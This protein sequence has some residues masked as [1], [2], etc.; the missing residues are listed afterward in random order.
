MAL[1]LD[2]SRPRR[3]ARPFGEVT[4]IIE[5]TNA[6]DAISQIADF[7]ARHQGFR[8][9]VPDTSF[10]PFSAICR[11][12]LTFPSGTYSGTG[13][14]IG[15]S[16][17]LSCG[18]NLFD[19]TPDGSS[20][21]AATAVTVRVGQQNATTWLDS[22][23][24][25]PSDWTVHPTWVS[26][27]ATN[28]GFDLSV[29]RVSHAPPGGNYF[30]MINYSPSPETPIA[31][32]G[33][34]GEDVDSDRQHLDIDRVRGLSDDFE[35]FD[36]NLQTRKGNSGS[37]V[38]AHFTNTSS[39]LPESIPVMGVHVAG[40]SGALNRGVLL[41]PDKIEWALG[42][43]ISSVSA[44][45]LGRSS[46][47]GLP[48]QRRNPAML[49]GLPLAASGRQ[50][51]LRT[52]SYARP[53]ERSWIVVDLSPTGGMGVPKRT[54]GHP[55]RD[56]SG[57]TTLSV[58]VPNMPAGGSVLWNIPDATHKTIAS[59]E[60]GG[61]PETFVS[62]L[63]AT[64]RS[65]NGGSFAVDCMV[66]DAAGKTVES[67]KYWLSSPQFVLVA[68][69][70][71]TDAFLTS[72]GLGASR[73][74][75]LAEMK[76][77]ME[78]IYRNVNMRFIFPGEALPA[79]L[80]IRANAAFPAGI[81]A[82]PSVIYAEMLGDETIMDPEAT[83]AA[84]APTAY[85]AGV[86]GRNH[87]PG[88]MAGPMAGHTLARGLVH[89][90]APLFPDINALQARTT[91]GT[92][93][94]AEMGRA[95][96]FY[97]R[98]MGENMAHEVAHFAVAA[99]QAH[100]PSGLTE[101]G[102]GRSTLERT[103]MTIN[104]GTGAI[105]DAGRATINDLPPDVLRAFEEHL[106]INPPHD[107]AGVTARGRVG[108]FSRSTG[109]VNRSARQ[110]SGEITVHLP[111]TTILDGWEAE[112]FVVA[113][114]TA[115][116]SVLGTN[117]AF[118]LLAPFVDVDL[119]LSAC[120]RAGATLALGISGTLGLGDGFGVSAGIVFAPGHRIG[121]YGTGAGVIGMIYNAGGSVQITLIDGG[122]EKLAGD[123]YMAGI[124]VATLG[125]F[126]AGTLDAPVGAHMLFDMAHNPI[127]VT[128]E[129]GISAGLPVISLIEAYG[130]RT[131]TVTTLARRR[132]GRSLSVPPGAIDH[133]VDTAIAHGAS[134]ADAQAFL[135][136]LIG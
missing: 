118:M 135:S 50:P 109:W 15:N 1:P 49:G 2:Y 114:E 4:P 59:L 16:L 130:Q 55:T 28:R 128:F 40:H 99:F 121:F 126:D 119:I 20:T 13:F 19:T 57:K 42:G 77:T 92:L 54:F 106:P 90:F 67:N 43:G 127:G 120:D 35:N 98:L 133:A 22:F 110:L 53:L 46:L 124:S 91:A 125:W 51:M 11:L 69:N 8:I 10:F 85:G 48:L 25:T 71:T 80:G 26:S 108:S 122:P 24:V 96:T 61:K 5:A 52:Q 63:N 113:L 47:G 75:I 78:H 32:C 70:P 65:L 7:V 103:G 111:G 102:S 116:R 88:D 12:K 76:A 60:S 38:F 34:G 17:I 82:Q 73:A 87:Q 131:K 33:Y 112:A 66:K 44:F 39:E 62:G 37:P 134:P 94:A 36:Y 45:S 105:T 129:F 23:E 86:L 89:R 79:H 100:T 6:W 117:P 115:M 14:Y 27:G 58:R 95:A 123:G 31:V 97:G 30:H 64:L 9:G 72:I 107:Q 83:L 136:R 101:D 104:L 68:I 132:H 56:A 41:T 84:G 18:H 81:E 3:A 93:P 21:E 29:I 74:A